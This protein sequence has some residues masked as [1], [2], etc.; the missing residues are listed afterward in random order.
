MDRERLK[1][2]RET[3]L[4]ESKVNEDFVQ[5]LKTKAPTYLLLILIVFVAVMGWERYRNW[6]DTKIESAFLD[7]DIENDPQGLLAVAEDHE[8]VESVSEMARL[9]SADISLRQALMMRD[10]AKPEELLDQAAIES[11][12]TR[13]RDLYQ[14]VYDATSA[15]KARALFAIQSA[16]GLATVHES[17]GDLEQARTW[18]DTAEKIAGERYGSLAAVASHRAQTL[19][20]LRDAAELRSRDDIKRP[21]PID[22]LLRDVLLDDAA[23]E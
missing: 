22:P 21:S 16:F 2:V 7:L 9:A 14:Q 15:D 5:W 8:G 23:P 18:Y 4:T 13:A 11:R 1:E 6:Q 10:P 3:D 12:L 17:T 20:P 19:D